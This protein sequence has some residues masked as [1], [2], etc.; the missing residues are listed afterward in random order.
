[1]L[2]S[3]DPV[4]HEGCCEALKRLSFGPIIGDIRTPTMILGGDRDKGAPPDIL[5]KAAAVIPGCRHVVVEG[6]GHI[7]NLENPA[8]V[9]AALE[10]FLSHVAA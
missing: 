1:M 3:T 7:S 5:A 4:G 2:R 6:A 10:G 9:N 8:A